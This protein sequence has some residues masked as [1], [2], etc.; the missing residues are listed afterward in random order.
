MVNMC[1]L[2]CTLLICPYIIVYTGFL[3]VYACVI[4]PGLHHTLL[5]HYWLGYFSTALT[6][7]RFDLCW[8]SLHFIPS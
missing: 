5:C 7:V 6:D 2:L 4:F 8:E 1:I 3:E